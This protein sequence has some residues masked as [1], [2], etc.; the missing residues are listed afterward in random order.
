MHDALRSRLWKK[1]ASVLLISTLPISMLVAVFGIVQPTHAATLVN[2]TSL[3]IG[4]VTNGGG[5]TG[6]SSSRAELYCNGDNIYSI[7][8]GFANV[9]GRYHIEVTGAS[10]NST[11][12][13]ADIYVSSTKA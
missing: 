11:A 8:S 10:S 4:V 7:N 6:L 3:K 9:P 5:C 13:S 1:F 2:S 12:Q